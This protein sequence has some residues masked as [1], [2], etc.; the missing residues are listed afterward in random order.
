[1]RGVN[2]ADLNIYVSNK[3]GNPNKVRH[4]KHVTYNNLKDNT[5][6]TSF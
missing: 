1:V 4:D 5:K 6:L 3:H 2:S